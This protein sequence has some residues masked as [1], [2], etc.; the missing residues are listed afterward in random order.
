MGTESVQSQWWRD[1]ASAAV[2]EAHGLNQH[3]SNVVSANGGDAGDVRPTSKLHAWVLHRWSDILLNRGVCKHLNPKKPAVGYV[4]LNLGTME[5][6]TCFVDRVARD[7]SYSDNLCDVCGVEPEDN[8]FVESQFGIGMLLFF[9]HA[10]TKCYSK[11]K[12]WGQT[13]VG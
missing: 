5:C 13:R 11:Q 12:L 2:R 7:E 4:V 9:W 8:Q 6:K 1:Q 3:I 10:C